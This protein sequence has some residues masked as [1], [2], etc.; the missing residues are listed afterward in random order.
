VG[1]SNILNEVISVL[2]LGEDHTC[3]RLLCTAVVIE[4][5]ETQFKAN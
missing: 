1:S 4:I 2:Y 5:K 3:N